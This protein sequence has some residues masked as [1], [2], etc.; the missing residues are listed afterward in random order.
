MKTKSKLSK[1]ISFLESAGWEKR[2]KLW[3]SPYTRKLQ[4]F[5]DHFV[6]HNLG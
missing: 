6:S 4:S 2:G 1:K 5:P 3:V